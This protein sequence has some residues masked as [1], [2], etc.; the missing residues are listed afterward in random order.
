[1]NYPSYLQGRRGALT[2]F[3]PPTTL[4]VLIQTYRALA[5]ECYVGRDHAWWRGY[6]QAVLGFIAVQRLVLKALPQRQP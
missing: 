6:R 2:D 3:G 4:N 1:M 5:A